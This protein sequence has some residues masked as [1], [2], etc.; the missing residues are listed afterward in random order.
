[1]EEIVDLAAARGLDRLTMSLLIPCGRAASNPGLRVFYRGIGDH[2][3]RARD[4][5]ESRGIGFVWY[6]PLPLCIFNTTIAHRLNNRGCAADDGLLHISPKERM[7]PECSSCENADAC[8]GACA[9][10]WR[11]VGR[12]ELRA[13]EN[14]DPRAT[15]EVVNKSRLVSQ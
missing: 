4:L 12:E 3:P 13:A 9:L 10:Y 1:M 11:A 2:V 14:G 8:Q 7:P 15:E 6:S 5:A